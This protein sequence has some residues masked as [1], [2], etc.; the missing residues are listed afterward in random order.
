MAMN[1]FSIRNQKE[2]SADIYFYGDI[3]S[4]SWGKWTDEDTC[5]QD[6]VDILKGCEDVK[7]LNIYINSGGG[8]V[9]G[10]VAIYNIL[11]RHSAKKIVHIDGLAASIASVIALAGDEII[12]PTNSFLMIHKA[13]CSAFGNA[14]DLKEA[15]EQLEKIEQSI[16][17][18]YMDNATDGNDEAHIKELMA[19]ETWLSASDAADLFK[20]ITVTEGLDAVACLSNCKYTKMPNGISFQNRGKTADP[21]PENK[22]TE[23]AKQ[24][25][26]N[27]KNFM[28]LEEENENE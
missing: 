8:S 14:D 9:W 26:E 22:I 24:T 17:N 11:K 3:V 10:G 7:E 23:E 13:M 12:M 5:P 16:I 28:F 6:I 4:D 20:H 19:A 2:D 27:L 21:V 15:A 1:F 25:L 18:I